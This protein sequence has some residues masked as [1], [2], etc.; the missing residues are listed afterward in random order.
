MMVFHFLSQAN[1]H[2][3]NEWL[4]LNWSIQF[5]IITMHYQRKK[6]SRQ[7]G[8]QISV[9]E[10]G[11]TFLSTKWKENSVDETERKFVSMKREENFVDETGRKFLSTKRIN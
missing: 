6:S 10:T 2:Y 8:K 7:K 4:I 9:D 1:I 11:R 5:L 3:V